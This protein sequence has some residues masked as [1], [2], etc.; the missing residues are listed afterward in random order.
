MK[1][2]LPRQSRRRT[3]KVCKTQRLY[4][5][6]SVLRL[7]PLRCASAGRIPLRRAHA[8]RAVKPR[9]NRQDSPPCATRERHN[10]CCLP[11]KMRSPRAESLQNAA[12]LRAGQRSSLAPIP[13]RNRRKNPAAPRPCKT[14][15]ET[16]WQPA[17]SRRRVRRA[18][19]ITLA[20]CKRALRGGKFG[21]TGA[22]EA[23][24][25]A[26]IAPPR[27]ESLQN[28]AALRAGHR[29]SL[30]PTPLRNRWE[31]PVAPRPCKTRRETSWQPAGQPAARDARKP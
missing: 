28:A 10:A 4:A 20:A 21:E 1:F 25:A 15:H 22:D 6:G 18:K 31:N 19:A 3:R 17:K 16:S 24:P 8:K 26:P 23:P 14:R 5:P 13:L 11:C 9:G 2:R 7:R 30:A 12:A 29:S 27:A